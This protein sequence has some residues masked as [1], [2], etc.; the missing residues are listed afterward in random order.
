[1]SKRI[2]AQTEQRYSWEQSAS[3]PEIKSSIEALFDADL[4]VF[5]F[6]LWWFGPP[7]ILK[8][9]L[10]RVFVYGALYRSS[11]RD[12]TGPC[13]GK[14]ALACVT[15]GASEEACSFNGHEGDTNL[16]LWPFL[17]SLRYVG[18][19]VLEPNLIFGV[20]GGLSGG[21]ARAQDI[22]L[23]DAE[24]AYHAKLRSLETWPHVPFNAD[25][26]FDDVGRLRQ[27]A[28]VYSP[29]I[30]HRAKITL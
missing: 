4:V 21:E 29:F 20:R 5:Q 16:I 2:D 11:A 7:G 19:S 6:P 8:G 14:R 1:M 18:F 25:S 27:D 24:E 26:N 3:A 17:F 22:H 28:S 12:D 15:T 13:R 23:R 30:R 9:W 10:D